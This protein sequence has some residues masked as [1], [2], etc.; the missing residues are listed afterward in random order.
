MRKK[1]NC[2]DCG[3]LIILRS[4]RCRSCQN[5]NNH[6][7]GEK[8]P[9]WKGNNVS[10]NALHGWVK[11][12]KPKPEL[13]EICKIKSP[14]DAANISGEYKR[15]IMDWEYLCRWCH[16]KKDGRLRMNDGRKFTEE[17]LKNMSLM[18]IGKRKGI[19]NYFYGKHHSEE[20]KEIL[21]LNR[22]GKRL[23]EIEKD[24]RKVILRFRTLQRN[25]FKIPIEYLSFSILN[26]Q[27]NGI[28]SYKDY[29][30]ITI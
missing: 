5:K 7:C 13:C 23:T 14:Y 4:I 3:K 26:Y 9:L 29:L 6:V 11:R 20:T 19:E 15:D 28:K 18:R 30:K 2:R 10:Y 22:L 25:I 1:S 12:N 24:R 17:H 27:I 8:H 16:M 21:R